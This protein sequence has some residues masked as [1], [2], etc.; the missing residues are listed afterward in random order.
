MI[1]LQ[2]YTAITADEQMRRRVLDEASDLGVD[3]RGD[4]IIGNW[5][6]ED[7]LDGKKYDTILA[8]YLV[9]AIDGFS[10]FF[11]ERIFER[12][13]SHLAPGGRLYVVGLQPIPDEVE[14]D[15]NVFCKVIVRIASLSSL[16]LNL[17]SMSDTHIP[18][19]SPK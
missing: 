12:I 13:S 9:G 18:A 6:D 17:T 1:T 14:G 19:R 2:D 11:Q 15:G 3:D 4:V 10:P 8:D 7:L 5:V 16:Q